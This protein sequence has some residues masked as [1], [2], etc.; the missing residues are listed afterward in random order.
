MFK[1]ALDQ[2]F[3]TMKKNLFFL[4][5]LVCGF[6]TTTLSQKSPDNRIIVTLPDS[7]DIYKLV[8][9]N[10]IENDFIVKENGNKDTVSTYPADMISIG[11]SVKLWASIKD[12]QV[13]FFGVFSLKKINYFGMNYNT[14]ESSRI[15]YF[16][17]SQ[18]WMTMYNIAQKLGG[19]ISYAKE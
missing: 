10:F 8:R 2:I 7:I 1:N 17:G 18:S 3:S 12:N 14:D 13:K 4:L 16:K 5:F 11:G 6:S 9:L 15:I 19:K